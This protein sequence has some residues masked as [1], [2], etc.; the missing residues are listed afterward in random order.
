MP[1][2]IIHRLDRVASTLESSGNKAQAEKLD[3]VSNSLEAF[4]TQPLRTRRDYGESRNAALG[5]ERELRVPLKSVPEDLHQRAEIHRISQGFLV[6]GDNK[7][8][9]RIRKDESLGPDGEVLET[10]YTMTAKHRP[11]FQEAETSISKEIFDNLW[12]STKK[13]MVKNRYKV[14][15]WDVDELT[16]GDS[17]GEV[18][19]E[20]EYSEGTKSVEIPKG[21]ELL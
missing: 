17:S 9:L 15:G 6:K 1:F 5:E 21:W 13:R 10:S 14:D 18:W 20:Y 19:A 4:L 2:Q 7:T 11:M 12:G 16:E 8:D 3:V